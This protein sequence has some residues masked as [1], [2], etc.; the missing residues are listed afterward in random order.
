MRGKG[1]VIYV[2]WLS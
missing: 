2:L 1:C